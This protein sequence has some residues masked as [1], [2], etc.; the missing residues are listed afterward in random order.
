MQHK[1]Q[2]F[3]LIA[4]FALL[5]L[6]AGS[7]F[8]QPRELVSGKQLQLTYDKR[9]SLSCDGSP[10]RNVL[11]DLQGTTGIS[12]MIDRRIDPGSPIT[13]TTAFTSHRNILNSVADKAG[14]IASL[15]EFGAVIGP[16]EKTQGLRTLLAI[17]REAVRKMRGKLPADVYQKL[18]KPANLSWQRLS[19]PRDEITKISTMAGLKFSDGEQIPHDLWAAGS[20]PSA[21]VSDFLTVVLFQFDRSFEITSNAQLLI[22]EIPEDL[23]LERRHRVSSK[24]KSDVARR[25]NAAF[26]DLSIKWRGTSAV[27]QT[28]VEIHEALGN[29]AKEKTDSATKDG[30][31]AQSFTLRTAAA[32][33]SVVATFRQRGTPIRFVGA[34]ESDLSE[35]LAARVELDIDQTPAEQFFPK[36]FESL[37]GSVTVTDSE[38]VV[39]VDK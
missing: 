5:L 13:L 24:R 16:K 30:L 9:G 26:P 31:R 6:N 23:T 10:L 14:G 18:T 7:S 35:Q 8:A 11:A 36:V 15:T 19:K 12:I 25:W 38:V 34:S 21:T 2:L 4:S 28:T 17:N 29:L 1:C 39:R 32:L 3:T 22:T 20:L 37:G 27:I 33:G